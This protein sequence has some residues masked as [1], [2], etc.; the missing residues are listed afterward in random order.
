L[1][2]FGA[3]SF[4]FQFAIQKYNDTELLFY[5]LFCMGVKLGPSLEFNRFSASQKN[6]PHFME[7]EG[8][9]YPIHQCPPPVPILSQ[10]NPV[11]TPTSYFL[12][13]HLN[14]ILPFTPRSPQWSLSF[15]FPH[16]TPVHTSPLPIRATCPA[17]L[18]L[19]DFITRTILGEEYRSLSS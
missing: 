9:L 16:Q 8:S 12:K 14:I 15:R 18:I 6:S 13:I 5:L 2:S 1:L 4:V 11:H 3:Q 10:P 19:F 7:P 17:H